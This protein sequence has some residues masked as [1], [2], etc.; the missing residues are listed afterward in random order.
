MGRPRLWGENLNLTLPV[1]AKARMDAALRP[2]EDRLALI[3]AA[4]DAELERREAERQQP[5]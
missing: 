2:G 4:I 5:G 3:R 1:G